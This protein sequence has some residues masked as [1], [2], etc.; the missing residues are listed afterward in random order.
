MTTIAS[1]EQYRNAIR[2]QL[3]GSDPALIQDALYDVDEYLRSERSS[4]LGHITEQELVQRAVEGFG[5]PGEVAASYRETEIQV[6]KAL[7]PPSSPSPSTAFSSGFLGVLFDPRAY[8]ALF[9]MLFSLLTGIFYF[10]WAVTGLA[11]SLGLSILILGVPFFI[12]FAGSIRI[13][14]LLEGRL[15]EGLIG[16]RMP[17]RPVSVPA[18]QGWL[19]RAWYWVSDGR[20]W[21]TLLYFVISL[22]FGVFTFAIATTLLSLAV[23][24][25]A[26]PLAQP[27]FD[28]PMIT[29]GSFEWFVPWWTFPGF[30]VAAVVVHLLMLHLAK[31]FGAARAGLARALLVR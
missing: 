25:F 4:A 31:A 6:N 2:F 16:V 26:L 17:R 14:A 30:W 28:Q 24:F 9:L 7:A 29:I 21:S 10:T 1:I 12:G 19:Q 13:L 8:G 15:L 20:T 23:S 22:P 18:K 27:F 3:V 11:M 5:T